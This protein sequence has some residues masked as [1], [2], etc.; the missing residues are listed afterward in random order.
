MIKNVVHGSELVTNNLNNNN[1]FVKFNYISML[2]EKFV[3]FFLTR[4]TE[5][6]VIRNNF[7]LK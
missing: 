7:L 2:S 4:R 5:H 6:L 3:I 1:N